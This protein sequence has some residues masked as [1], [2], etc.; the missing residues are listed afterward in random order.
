ML[1]TIELYWY[2]G[3]SNKVSFYNDTLDESSY[4]GSIEGN[5]PIKLSMDI[6]EDSIPVI[7]QV[8]QDKILISS[9]VLANV[10]EEK[11]EE[12]EVG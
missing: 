11:D 5:T 2:N 9:V 6:R 10:I 1:K 4:M 7:K 12:S 3:L 8:S